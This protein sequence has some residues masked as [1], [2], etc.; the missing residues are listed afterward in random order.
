MTGRAIA[1]HS[2]QTCGPAG[3]R[4]TPPYSRTAPATSAM[5]AASSAQGLVRFDGLRFT[6]VPVSD[7]AAELHVRPL[8]EP[9]AGLAGP[10]APGHP[11]PGGLGPPGVPA[12]GGD[13]AQLG[14]PEPEPVG[15][16]LV[17]RGVGLVDAHL[18]HR[19][20]L[21]EQPVELQ[22]DGSLLVVEN[23][24]LVNADEAAVAELVT[25]LN[26]IADELRPDLTLAND[27]VFADDKAALRLLGEQ[28][29]LPV[30]HADHA[31]DPGGGHAALV[32]CPPGP[33]HR[34]P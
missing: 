31:V 23:G 4:A 1:A 17:D 15:G 21:V 3:R 16:Q 29:Q 2:L 24:R 14:R 5:L 6:R 25:Q 9:L 8:A 33:E 13:E 32:Q 34:E 28:R 11:Q 7:G 19:E 10:V 12:V 27:P 20:D 22:P 18:L 30:V 26:A